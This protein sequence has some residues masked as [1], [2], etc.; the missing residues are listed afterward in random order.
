MKEELNAYH[1]LE[2]NFWNDLFCLKNYNFNR[3]I[4]LL[5]KKKHV[6]TTTHMNTCICIFASLHTSHRKVL[7][8]LCTGYHKWLICVCAT[9]KNRF[10]SD[11]VV[12]TSAFSYPNTELE[13]PQIKQKHRSHC[14][15]CSAAHKQNT[16]HKITKS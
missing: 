7:F 6:K 14:T 1:N 13:S 11:F 5:K 4:F 2:L 15:R 12:E 8:E 10:L 16:V 9:I 3:W